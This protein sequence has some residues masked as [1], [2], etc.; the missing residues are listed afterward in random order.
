[1]VVV[2]NLGGAIVRQYQRDVVFPFGKLRN[3]RD[4]GIRLMIALQLRN[5]QIL[6]EIT[7][8]KNSTI[9]FPRPVPQKRP[10]PDPIR[11]E[12]GRKDRRD[13]AGTWGAQETGGERQLRRGLSRLGPGTFG[14]GAPPE[15]A[16][17]TKEG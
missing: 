11:G 3:V 8:E 5:L 14:S 1:M 16:A 10:R 13:S 7:A 15:E 6:A 9:V 12:R 2:P 4:P 17:F